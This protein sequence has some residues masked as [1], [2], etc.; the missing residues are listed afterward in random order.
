MVS[1]EIYIDTGSKCYDGTKHMTTCIGL[2][3]SNNAVQKAQGLWQSK[4]SAYIGLWYCLKCDVSS[5]CA[6]NDKAWVFV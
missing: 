6:K 4:M 5:Q 3:N 1:T 2:K